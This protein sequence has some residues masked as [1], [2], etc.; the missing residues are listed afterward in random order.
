MAK[1]A[2]LGRRLLERF[3]R[4]LEFGWH[5]WFIARPVPAAETTV[6]FWLRT[7]PHR[8]PDGLHPDHAELLRAQRLRFESGVLFGAP[9]EATRRGAVVEAAIIELGASPGLHAVRLEA[10]DSAPWPS[11]AG[12]RRAL[13]RRSP[14]VRS[15]RSPFAARRR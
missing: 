12:P 1:A 15:Q 9:A 11:L 2:I 8:L 14:R 4:S 5:A 7:A 6:R 10:I 13:R 3:W